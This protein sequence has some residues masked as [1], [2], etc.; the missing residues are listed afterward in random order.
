VTGDDSRRPVGSRLQFV[1]PAIAALAAL[2]TAVVGVLA[3]TRSNDGP[4]VTTT[5]VASSVPVISAQS[6]GLSQGPQETSASAPSAVLGRGVRPER[7]EPCRVPTVGGGAA[8]Q[9]GEATIRGQEFETA[10][11]CNLDAG[12]SGALEFVLGAR[13]EQL[14]LTIGFSD[15]AGSTSRRVRFE[16]IGDGREHLAAPRELTFGTAEDLVVDVSGITRLLLRVTELNP[17]GGS[18]SPSRPTFGGMSLTGPG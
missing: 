16:I 3:F 2:T 5:S 1:W 7:S 18:G 14:R 12:A 9:L 15:I 13:Y 17:P 11:F 6:G 4:S 10:Y 8:W